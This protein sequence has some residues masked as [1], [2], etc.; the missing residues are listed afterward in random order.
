MIAHVTT[1]ALAGLLRLPVLCAATLAVQP[2]ATAD[3]GAPRRLRPSKQLVGV[4]AAIVFGV[5]VKWQPAIGALDTTGQTA[6]AIMAAGVALLVTD[7]LPAG[8]SAV[9]ILGMLIIA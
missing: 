7:V 5:V 2:T 3:S 1:A 8:I 9:L 4:V 6:L